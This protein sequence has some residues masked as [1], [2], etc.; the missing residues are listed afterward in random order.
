MRPTVNFCQLSMRPLSH[1]STSANF[2]CGWECFSNLPSTSVPQEHLLSTFINS[3]QPGEL[4]S[5]SINFPCDWK[6]FRQLSMQ[7]IDLLSISGNFP[8]GRESFC[9]LP[10]TFRAVWRLAFYTREI[11]VWPVDLR[12]TLRATRRP[13]VNFREHSV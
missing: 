7:L 13:S 10:S 1:A 4:L 9:E 3:V 2:W 6:T 11:S 5:H 8:Y 12:G